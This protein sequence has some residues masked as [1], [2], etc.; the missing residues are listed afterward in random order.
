[1]SELI[2]DLY[3]EAFYEQFSSVLKQTI[4]SVNKDEFKNLIFIDA[5]ES[6]ELKERLSHT[7]KVLNHFL[8]EDFKSATQTIKELIENL[9]S[10][11]MREQSME[12]MFIPE[13]IEI[14][15]I[16]D[17]ENSVKAFEFIT[18]FTS[19]EF[20]VRPFLKKYPDEMLSQMISWS[21]H[22]NN[23]VRR[24]A[25]EGSR[26][27]LPWA[28]ALPSYKN[29]PS[30]ILPILENLKEDS[31]EVVRRSVANN[32]NDIAKDNPDTVIDISKQ[33]K[34]K[35]KETDALVKHACRTLLKQGELQILKLFGFG[36]QNFKV[37]GFNIITPQVKI[38]DYLGFKFSI[39]NQDDSAKLLRLEYG[40]YYMKNN[41]KLARKVFKISEREIESNKI[42]D[43]Q[44]KQSFKI[45]S[46]RKFHTGL[47]QVS[48]IVNG[49][50]GEKLDFEL[51][52]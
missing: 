1:M 34:G 11:N 25:S 12:F 2:K 17:Y 40:L 9:N 30:P 46:T 23:K 44:R 35:S 32:L 29:D 14:Y 47:H 33:W 20:A 10:A 8:P 39:I 50:E 5:F 42:Y 21:K 37:S 6:Y 15:G 22:E 3:S 43:I 13:Y 51:T 19:C 31:C 18:Q 27:R 16:N 24:L 38:G 36:S 26:P 41:G 48:I 28:M 52:S 45:I 49:I 4:P 7:T